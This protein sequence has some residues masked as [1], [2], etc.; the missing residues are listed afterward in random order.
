MN[1]F[2][3][4]GLRDAEGVGVNTVPPEEL[5]ALLGALSPAGRALYTAVRTMVD[6]LERA[7][8]WGLLYYPPDD[9]GILAGRLQALTQSIR[10]LHGRLATCLPAFPAEDPGPGGDPL[11]A[12]VEFYFDSVLRMI[13]KDLGRLEAA[14]LALD[15]AHPPAAEALEQLCELAADLKGKFS[16]SIMSATVA[17]VAQGRWTSAQIEPVLFPEKADEARR[18]R[19]LADHLRAIVDWLA[20]LTQRLPLAEIVQRWKGG[21]RADQY[22]FS[23]L[24]VLRGHLGTLLRERTRRALYSGDYYQIRLRETQLAERL[25]ELEWL[26]RRTWTGSAASAADRIANELPRLIQLVREIAAVIDVEQLTA[27]VGEKTVLRL[28]AQV[29]ISAAPHADA[30][31]DPIV[32]LLAH[33][34][35]RLFF[36]MLLG[37]VQRRAALAES[38][39]LSS[40]GTAPTAVRPLPLPVRA[41][42]PSAAPAAPAPAPLSAAQQA[43]LVQDLRRRLSALQGAQSVRWNDFRLVQHMLER[44]RRMPD[45]MTR[46]ARPFIEELHTVIVPDLKRL[47]PYRGLTIELV[48]RLD[49]TCRALLADQGLTAMADTTP[50][51]RLER[52]QRFLDALQAVMGG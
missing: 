45:E 6:E 18:S 35:L 5:R 7:I 40:A 1:D 31:F 33:D 13:D 50:L 51:Q 25:N 42:V 52:L 24:V 46:G 23:D 47:A 21:E 32:P 43:L 12:E 19:E 29:G 10:R 30:P 39:R 28:R 20:E 49:G 27:I 48:D 17:L 14:T 15:P 22:A 26:H 8:S 16:S 36:N 9:L 3:E 34:D 2:F 44:H 41:P 38:D 37:A 4:F 11:R